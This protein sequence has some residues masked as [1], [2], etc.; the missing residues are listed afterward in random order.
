MRVAFFG[1]IA[2]Q[3]VLDRLGADPDIELVAPET[4]PEMVQ[5]VE[6][7]EVLI[8][9]D[10]R[11]DFGTALAQALNSGGSRVRWV[12]LVSA[13]YAGMLGHELPNDLIVTNQGG[14]VAP[15][16]AEHA[17]A[18]ILSHNRRL[19]LARGYQAESRWDQGL[20]GVL[21]VLEGSTAVIVGLGHVGRAVATRLRPFGLRLIG[22]NRSGKHSELFDEVLAIADVD[23][24]LARADTVVLCLP[25]SPETQGLFDAR[26]IATIKRDALLVNVGRGDAIDPAALHAALVSG[27]LG[28]AAIDVT[29]PEPLPEGDPLWQAPNLTITPHVAGAG[30]ALVAGRVADTVS[31]NLQRFT[32]GTPLLHQVYPGAAN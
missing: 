19:G 10:P 11:G 25:S 27:H 31:G 20:R 3:A 16:V 30:S 32:E 4:Q 22:V 29:E 12:Q 9:P 15:V 5:E 24:A 6:R 17:L 8:L 1:P 13:G 28:G 26:R 14:A 18:L 23:Q 21:R 7:S 2:R